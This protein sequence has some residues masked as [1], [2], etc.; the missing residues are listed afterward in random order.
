MLDSLA[1]VDPVSVQIIQSNG[2]SSSSSSMKALLI[3]FE[4]IF[5]FLFS[6]FLKENIGNSF[7]L[8]VET[9][10][11]AAVS[12][13]GRENQVYRHGRRQVVGWVSLS[14]SLSVCLCVSFILVFL[15]KSCDMDP[16]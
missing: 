3:S 14:L 1:S 11:V 16:N 15:K 2:A 4:K 13:T 7:R 12:R 9:K 10:M 8:Q 5:S 6:S